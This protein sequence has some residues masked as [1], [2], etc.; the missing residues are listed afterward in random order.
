MSEHNAQNSGNNNNVNTIIKNNN[1][2]NV[3]KRKNENM[4]LPLPKQYKNNYYAVLD[5]DN[6]T[7]CDKN[8][9]NKFVN[10]VKPNSANAAID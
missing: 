9:L 4:E 7:V 6:D 10:H 3:R 5:T 1:N 8:L 2:D